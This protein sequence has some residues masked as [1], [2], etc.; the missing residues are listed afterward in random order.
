MGVSVDILLVVLTHV[1]KVIRYIA[2]LAVS[3]LEY[4]YKHRYNTTTTTRASDDVRGEY[5]LRVHLLL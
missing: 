4:S 1:I 5:C 2:H 3:S